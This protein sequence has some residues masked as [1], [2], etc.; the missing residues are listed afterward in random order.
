MARGQ[1]QLVPAVPKRSR[2]LTVDSD[3]NF[4]EQGEGVSPPS[5]S[6]QNA[7]EIPQVPKVF[8]GCWDG[9]IT[10]P[11]SW[12]RVKGPRVARWIPKTERLCFKKTGDGPFT[13]TFHDT[14]LDSD[15]AS[16]MGYPVSNYDEQTELVS[17]DGYNEVSLH[18]VASFD[19]KTKILGLIWGSVTRVSTIREVNSFLVDGGTALNVEASQ[20]TR[21]RGSWGCNGQVWIRATWHARFQKAPN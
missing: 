6:S 5:V 8:E 16:R 12:E 4:V 11:D 21:C 18:T 7:L 9:T 20:V 19:E 13:I 17:T 14:K 1:S 15:Y 3:G 10:E 2:A